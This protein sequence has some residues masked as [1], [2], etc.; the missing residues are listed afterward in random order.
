MDPFGQSHHLDP[1]RQ[2]YSSSSSMAPFRLD[3]G[4][5]EDASNQDEHGRNMFAATA[6]RF[7]EW[8]MAQNEDARAEIAYEVL[9]TLRTSNIAAVVERLMPLLHMDPLQKLPPEIT[10]QI[11]SSLDSNTL[12][13]ASLASQT[14]RAR[15]MDTMLWQELYKNQGWG[16]DAKEIRQFENAHTSLVRQEFKKAR[17]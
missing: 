13:T 16:L 14:W 3:E 10:S 1:H 2:P 11:F 7:Q 15:I 12:L 9:R 4:F 8:V 5:S 17:G 6:A